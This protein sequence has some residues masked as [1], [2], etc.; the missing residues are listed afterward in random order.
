LDFSKDNKSG[1]RAIVGENLHFQGGFLSEFDGE[2]IIENGFH[3]QCP[4]ISLGTSVGA[5]SLTG[6]FAFMAVL[7]HTDKNGQV[8]RSAPS[9]IEVSSAVVSKKLVLNIFN[10][11]FGRR[12]DN[13]VVEF[14]RTT[15]GPGTTFYYLR[16]HPVDMYSG[17]G[18][19]IQANIED[20]TLDSAI[21]DNAIIYTAGGV[22]GNDPGPSCKFLT[23]GGNR[24]I[25][26]GLPDPNEIA[27]SKKKLFGETV[28]FSDFF[29]IRF[30]TSQ[31]NILGGITA[32][33]Y[34][35]GK[36]IGFKSNSIFF[37]AGD[38]P[39]EAGLDDNFTPPELISSETGCEE[40]RSVVLG[41]NGLFFKSRK[42]IY[43]LTRGLET[44]Y[45]GAAVEEF[46]SYN[47]SSAVHIDQENRV[48]FTLVSSDTNKKFILSYDYFSQQWSVISGK[49]G[50]DGD[51][52]NG[53]HLVLD[54]DLKAPVLQNG[55]DFLDGSSAYSMKVKTPW[56]KLSGLQDFGRIWSCTIL[57]KYKATHT[58]TVKVYYDYDAVTAT[59]YNVQPSNLDKQYQYRI[60]LAQQKCE[61]I[62]FEIYDTAQSGESMELTALTLEVGL[63]KGSMKLPA[64]RKY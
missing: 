7:K 30:D 33:G 29:R 4:D 48:V 60:H 41:P 43:L 55:V 16:E 42:G 52:Y 36:F 56:I 18:F 11:P 12:V 34:M 40:P 27:Y 13:C 1:S 8:T 63:R 50:I 46:N 2:N 23:Q 3:L 49:R 24:L 61:S 57:G 17:S 26:G 35:D 45:I 5:G 38:G 19:A 39:N 28:N 51:L 59:T 62:Q 47:V 32:A 64:T 10:M 37:V 25:L 9:P 53:Q 31:Y 6:T 54:S 22:L 20:D 44:Q 14:Y 58:L 15:N 21:V